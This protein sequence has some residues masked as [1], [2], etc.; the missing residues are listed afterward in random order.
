MEG[1]VEENDS[2]FTMERVV[3]RELANRIVE[4]AILAGIPKGTINYGT[5]S[6]TISCLPLDW[7]AIVPLRFMPDIP[8]VVITPS[9]DISYEMHLEFGKALGRVVHESQKRVGLIASCD[10]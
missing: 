9:R 8:I 10:W 7:G 2:S 4:E 1:T 3:D 5:S 6:G